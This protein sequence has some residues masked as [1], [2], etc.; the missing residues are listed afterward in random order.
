M[1]I[2]YSLAISFGIL[3]GIGIFFWYFQPYLEERLLRG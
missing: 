2:L 1:E 3:A